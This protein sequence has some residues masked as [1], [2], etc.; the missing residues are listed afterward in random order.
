V[1]F[2]ATAGSPAHGLVDLLTVVAHELGHQLGLEHGQDGDDVMYETL[3]SGAR[4]TPT[5]SDAGQTGALGLPSLPAVSGEP[6]LDA[7]AAPALAPEA[8]AEVSLTPEVTAVREENLPDGVVTQALPPE[9][10]GDGDDLALIAGD[11]RQWMT[12]LVLDPGYFDLGLGLTWNDP[13]SV[14][15]PTLRPP[16]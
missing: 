12:M 16:Q 4:R 7:V 9:T 2:P 10:A 6:S 3:T 11:T 14:L 13:S 15:V 1:E 5:S 8:S